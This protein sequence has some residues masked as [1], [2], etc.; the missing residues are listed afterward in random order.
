MI[1]EPNETQLNYYEKCRN[2]IIMTGKLGAK[3]TLDN[4]DDIAKTVRPCELK[5]RFFKQ[6]N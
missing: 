2:E 1:E 3:L 5:F 4:I 6:Q